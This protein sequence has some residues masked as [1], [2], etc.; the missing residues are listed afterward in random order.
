MDSATQDRIQS[1]LSGDYDPEVQSEI[2]RLMKE[3]PDE[4][5]DAFY[6][7]L[8]FG[9]GGMRGIMGVGT[10]RMN[11]YTIRSATQGLANY[12]KKQPQDQRHSVFIGYD[13]RINSRLFAEETARVLAGNGIEVYITETICPTPLASFGCRFLHC[14]AAIMITAS[15]NPPQYNGYKVYWSDGAQ[16]VPP[17]DVGIIE[18]V[19]K[20]HHLNEIHL[21]ELSDPLVHWVREEIDEAYLQQ[22]D[23]LSFFS[24]SS[25]ASLK[26]IYSNL[27]GTGL[28]LVPPALKRRKFF[29]LV[30]VKEQ[31]SLDG[32]FPFAPS[33]NPEEEKAMALG[34]QQLLAQQADLF[35]A[36]DPDADRLGVVVKDHGQSI[37]LNG[38]QIACL[39]LSYIA[40]FL[41]M[42]NELPP[43]AAFVKTIVTSEMARKIA[44]DYHIECFDV[45]TGF[46]YIAERIREWEISFN[47]KQFIFGAEESH[48]YLISTFVR[49]KDA[50]SAAC[51]LCEAA[52]AAKRQNRTLIDRL[53]DLYRTYGVYRQSLATI[54][55]DDSP[56]GMEKMKSVTESLRKDPPRSIHQLQVQKMDDYLSQ[57]STDLFTRKTM[58]ISLPISDVLTFWLEDQS[59]LVIRPS[60]T[61]P[62][63]KIYAEVCTPPSPQVEQHISECDQK[64]S[65]LVNALKLLCITNPQRK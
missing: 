49:D 65:V 54:S 3:K 47:G 6:R 34:S 58:P 50:I 2:H 10:N 21:K 44:E 56:E 22:L 41:K 63:I 61:E 62:K 46:K 18:E 39:C 12:L 20:I 55:F 28:R 36:T 7:D 42:K 24:D 40:S 59:K 60:G 25:P 19:R 33:P 32:H 27:H 35:L 4:L 51:L 23:K 38:N 30:L 53:H 14:S 5:K 57:R 8:S 64:L 16:I 9:T 15:H 43:N 11:I 1:W 31:Q 13:V 17:H 29:H 37:R 52:E 45:L 48:G 26:I